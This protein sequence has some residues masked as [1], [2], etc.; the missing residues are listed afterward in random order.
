MKDYESSVQQQIDL[1]IKEQQIE[2][3]RFEARAE[4]AAKAAS[5]TKSFFGKKFIKNKRLS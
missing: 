2:I 3:A 1:K 5:Q 4:A